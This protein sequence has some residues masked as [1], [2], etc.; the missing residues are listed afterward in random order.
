MYVKNAKLT[1]KL[2][3]SSI[4]SPCLLYRNKN[5]LIELANIKV[6]K[7]FGALTFSMF[8]SRAGNMSNYS[9]FFQNN[10]EIQIFIAIFGF[11]MKNDFKR[12][13]TSLVLF[14]GQ[15]H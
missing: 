13:Q 6:L 4:I 7:V 12:I 14:Q 3:K 10:L 2:T 9:S 8:M 15:L 11:S 5:T 1:D